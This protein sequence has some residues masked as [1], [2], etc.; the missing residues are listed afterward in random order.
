MHRTPR[1]A[2]T[3]GGAALAALALLAGGTAASAATADGEA[4]GTDEVPV[5]GTFTYHDHFLADGAEVVGA[6]HA[7]RRIEG[8]TAVYY[9]VGLPEDTQEPAL[10]GIVAFEESVHPYGV[11]EAAHVKL[12]DAAHLTAY[13]PLVGERAFT[14]TYLGMEVPP[15][16]LVTV[17][18]VFPELPA[19]TTTVDLQLEYG[20]TVT[21]VPVEDGPLE[22]AQ[23]AEYTLLGEGWPALPTVAEIATADPAAVTFPMFS[24]VTDPTAATTET[25]EQ[26]EVVLDA[27]VLF[28]PDSAEVSADAKARIEEVAREMAA[29]G[30]GE[31]TVTGHTDSVQGAVDNQALSE[32]R[33]QAVAALLAPALEGT[34]VTLAVAGKGP[35]EPVA[36]NGTEQGRA[37]NRRV[38]VVYQV[39]EDR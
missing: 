37:D 4:L 5:H 33:A 35:A 31:A 24:L 12:V 23:A 16:Q 11:G 1:P 21:G 7:V 39:G 10:T 32:Q 22:P 17:F 15:G 2:R 28:A 34:E 14:S 3:A 18:A 27:N 13:L 9:S 19:S 38:T 30:V 36:D 25:A 29:R 8:G 6:V 26:V 20:V